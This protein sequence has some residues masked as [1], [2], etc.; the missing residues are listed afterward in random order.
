MSLLSNR[1]VTKPPSAFLE[2]H[3]LLSPFYRQVPSVSALV[4]FIGVST[5]EAQLQ[6]NEWL[7]Y[8]NFDPAPSIL[9]LGKPC[10]GV[11]FVNGEKP[12]DFVNIK[13]ERLVQC[14]KP[15]MI[16]Q[17]LC[18]VVSLPFR[19]RVYSPSTELLE[20]FPVQLSIEL[21]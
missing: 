18:I 6:G 3:T 11:F 5:V 9:S 14:H 19:D 10:I 1:T 4:C 12:Q 7:S 21:F 8:L 2:N 13:N 17:M 16:K 15:C 20:T